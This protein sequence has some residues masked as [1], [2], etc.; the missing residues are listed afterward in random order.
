MSKSRLARELSLRKLIQQLDEN[1]C[2]DVIRSIHNDL[3]FD[4]LNQ[5]LIKIIMKLT[6]DTTIDSLTKIE[7]TVKELILTRQCDNETDSKVNKNEKKTSTQNSKLLRLPIDVSHKTALYLNN[8]VKHF[9]KL[10]TI[11]H[12]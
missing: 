5:L 12:I 2:M 4:N 6:D 9:I 8:V 10:S 11:Y 3:Q 7:N 1:E